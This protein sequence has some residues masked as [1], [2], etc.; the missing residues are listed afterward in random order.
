MKSR[1]HVF[2]DASCGFCAAF[3]ERFRTLLRRRGFDLV[4]LQDR[5]ASA[6]LHV[7]ES[8][9]LDEMRLLTHDRRQFSGAEALLHLARFIWWAKPLR[10]FARLPGGRSLLRRGYR[11]FAARRHCV[12]RT[13]ALRKRPA[14]PGWAPLL[15]LPPASAMATAGRPAWLHMWALAFAIF[16][17][18]KWLTWWDTAASGGSRPSLRRTLGYLFLWPGMDAK[19]FLFPQVLARRPER[20]NWLPAIGQ[21][22]CGV[23]LLW[24]ILPCLDSLQPLVTGWVGMT[25]IIFLLHFGAFHLLAL[26]WQSAGV[27]AEPIMRRPIAARSLGEFWGVRWNRGF[28]DLAHQH[29]FRPA[30]PHLGNSGATLLTFLV[31]GLLHELV[32][33]IP[34]RGGF[35]LPVSYFAVQGVGLL[36]ERSR[37]GRRAGLR[38]G[39]RGRVFA[40]G[41]VAAPAFFLFH[42]PFVER[43]ILP[44]LEA[45]GAG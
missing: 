22:L 14:W 9:L 33:S 24:G 21:T 4:P 12:G 30:A 3:A 34:A 26:L 32:I 10:W 8:E 38:R 27:A 2:Y 7:A 28:N 16:A 44:F 6:R 41:V 31:S 40:L 23:T 36:A 37:L 5:A 25:G 43:V 13:C 45:I 15:L 17:G 29:V 11:W 35:G 19:T 39:L 1:G 20:V 42:P 18:C